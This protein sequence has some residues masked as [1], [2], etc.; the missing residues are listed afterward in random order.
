MRR[1]VTMFLAASL[2]VG[3]A[4]CSS[5][6]DGEMADGCRAVEAMAAALHS[7]DEAAFRHADDR[8]GSFDTAAEEGAGNASAEADLAAAGDAADA[9]RRAAYTVSVDA[10][11]PA[12]TPRPLHHQEQSDVTR[13]LT[14]CQ[15]Y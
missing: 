10:I 1:S 7:R 8:T 11:Q 12:W 5:A 3:L 6:F 2:A 14:V 13:G 4:G 9:L 15:A